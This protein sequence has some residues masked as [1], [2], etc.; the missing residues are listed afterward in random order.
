MDSTGA[1]KKRSLRWIF[2]GAA[3]AGLA[4]AYAGAP[5]FRFWV[6]RTISLLAM[7]DFHALKMFILS[8]GWWA[9]AVS[10]L[11]M[12]L[13]TLAAPLPAFVLAIANAMAFGVFY[14]FLLTCFSAMLS[15]FMAFYLA[16]WLGRPFV[17][18][19][20][21][22][23]RLDAAIEHYGSWG[24]LVLRLF[25][26]VSFDFISFAAG[27]TAMRP[28]PFGLASLLG[29]IPAALAFSLL[30]E[31]IESA[32]RWSFMGGLVLFLLLLLFG[33]GVRRSKMWR[34]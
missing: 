1:P 21:G 18:K 20:L 22:G 17:E 23:K 6:D 12:L 13:Q 30:G 10:T 31:S 4:A 32:S 11:L 34:G 26:V 14:G 9:P 24:V 27:L 2:A 15:A 19:W 33:L 28:L 5:D 29:M 3:L 16:R 7:G 25:P 8:F